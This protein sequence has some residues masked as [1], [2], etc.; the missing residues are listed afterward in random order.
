MASTPSAETADETPD[1]FGA[2]PSLGEV[3]LNLPR[4]VGSTRPFRRGDELC[5]AG[6]CYQ[7][8]LVVLVGR[9]AVLDSGA[10]GEEQ[11]IAVHGPHRFLGELGLV[12]GEVAFVSAR[13]LTDGEVLAVPVRR[14]LETVA[15]SSLLADLILRAYLIR[16]SMLVELSVGVRVVGS[17][18]SPDTRR[19]REYAARNRLPHRFVDLEEDATAARLLDGLGVDPVDT[20]IVILHGAEVLRNPTNAELARLI[21]LPVPSGAEESSD[22]VVVGAGPAG[23]AAAVY[24]ASEGLSTVVLEA[25]ASGGQAGTSPRIENYLGFPSGI[26]GGEL[27]ERAAIQ[28]RRFGARL[29]MPGDACRYAA[30]QGQHVIGLADGTEVLGRTV[31]IAT[32]ARYRRLEIPGIDRFEGISVFYAATS[33]E[34]QVCGGR[35]VAVVGGG[36]SAGQASLYLAQIATVR[37]LVR[38]EHLE[39]SMSHYLAARLRSNASVEIALHHEPREL[40]GDS[41][42]EEVVVEDTHTGRRHSLAARALFVF[43][44]ADPHVRWLAGQLAVDDHGFILTG[45][46]AT[47]AG[48][49]EEMPGAAPQRMPLETTRRGVFAVGDVRSGSIKRVTAAAGEGAMAVRLVHDYLDAFG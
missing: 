22:L 1:L 31:L 12:V 13:A 34:A 43:I 48:A 32:G 3:E 37:L 33:V 46:R 19:L 17:R 47:S 24:G 4:E 15:E 2:Y 41:V 16:R 14:L 21:G 39:A 27:A 5:R 44:G 40:R 11:V 23:L 28:A 36:N 6:Q 38:G 29:V 7:D 35:T 49:G 8:F 45:E 25:V 18:F 20:P 26:S 30:S 10:P 9:V 42:L